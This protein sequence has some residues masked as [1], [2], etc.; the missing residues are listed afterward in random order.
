METGN[1]FPTK[2]PDQWSVMPNTCTEPDQSELKKTTFIGV[3]KQLHTWKELIH[4]TA[5]FLHGAAVP[6]T[7]T[8]CQASDYIS[9]QRMHLAQAH[10]DSFPQEVKAL[11]TKFSLKTHFL[12]LVISA[13]LY[14]SMMKSL[15]FSESGKTSSNCRY[16]TRDNP[17]YCPWPITLHVFLDLHWGIDGV[18]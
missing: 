15:D 17:P 13:P 2:T 1:R 4:A 7:D 3:V 8:V 6:N 16:G 11:K 12:I 5:R 9:T 18:N 14:L 10:A